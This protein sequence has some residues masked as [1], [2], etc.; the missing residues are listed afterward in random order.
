MPSETERKYLIDPEQWAALEKPLPRLI[1][2]GYLMISPERNIRVRLKEGKATLTIKGPL[3]GATRAEFEYQ[4]PEE[5]ALE[6]LDHYCISELFKNRY[7]IPHG[8]FD[9]EVDEFLGNNA[10]LVLAEIELPDETTSFE[11]PSWVGKEVTRDGRYY[12]PY[13]SQNRFPEPS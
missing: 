3:K 6:L 2:Q 1:R 9:W 8:G 4:V 7:V 13:L 10:G 11:L 12:N 5:D